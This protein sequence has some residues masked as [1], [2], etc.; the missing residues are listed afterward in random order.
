MSK[1]SHFLLGPRQTGKSHL[2]R[3]ALAADERLVV[4]ANATLV[5]FTNIASDA[6]V[7]RTTV[8]EYFEILKDTLIL[9]EVPW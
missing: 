6:Q 4:I 2:I 9:H 7:P 1:K 5:N 3:Q 8:Y